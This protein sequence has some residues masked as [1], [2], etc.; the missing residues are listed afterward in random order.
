MKLIFAFVIVIVSFN[1]AS[2]QELMILKS[3]GKVIIGDT[4]Q[5]STPGPYNLYVQNGMMTEKVKVAVKSAA[6]WSD[7]SF[8]KTPAL[9]DVK[10]SIDSKSHL[11]NMPSAEQ[12]V[13][14]GYELQA[15]DAKILEQVEWLWQHT[16][17]L[18][19]EN[20][21]L[22]AELEDIKKQLAKKN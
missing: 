22:K 2:S 4:S 8:D 16:I 3:S 7:D 14:E 1:I 12:L 15:M 9:N 13:K 21:E 5:I 19:E 20:K 11:V 17:K 6:D 18:S 10:A